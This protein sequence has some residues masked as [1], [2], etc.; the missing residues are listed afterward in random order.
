MERIT[1][2]SNWGY[3]DALEGSDIKDGDRLRVEWPDS[4]VT[5][6][7]AIVKDEGYDSSHEGHIPDTVTYVEVWVR[8]AP[9]RVRLRDVRTLRAERLPKGGL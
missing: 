6:E 3:F 4:S 1:V 9:A 8:G 2:R 5:D 7:T